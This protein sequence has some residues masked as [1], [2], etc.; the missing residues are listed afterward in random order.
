MPGDFF[1]DEEMGLGQTLLTDADMGILSDAEMGIGVEPPGAFT[2]NPFYRSIASMNAANAL[3]REEIGVTADTVR[4]EELGGIAAPMLAL[5][6]LFTGSLQNSLNPQAMGTDGTGPI[7]NAMDGAMDYLRPGMSAVDQL[8]RGAAPV[9]D[10]AL[11]EADAGAA[12]ENYFDTAARYPRSPDLAEF[13]ADVTDGSFLEGLGQTVMNP[14][15]GSRMVASVGAESSALMAQIIAAYAVG[16]PLAGGVV[17]GAT[18]GNMTLMNGVIE[19][20]TAAGGD[21]TDRDT[22]L[23]FLND[24]EAMAP[25]ME[26][27]L[28]RGVG[29][30]TVD[31]IAG[32][33]GG[34][35][36]TGFHN[37]TRGIPGSPMSGI[38]AAPSRAA[39]AT[40][41]GMA[42]GVGAAELGSQAAL[43]GAGEAVGQVL[44]E[45]QIT[46]P[47]DILL[48]TM[49]EFVTS[50]GSVAANIYQRD[51]AGFRRMVGNIV[52]GRIN[53][54]VNEI[55]FDAPVD[56]AA[57]NDL[58]SYF[59][60]EAIAELN[61]LGVTSTEE[62]DAIAGIAP[63][64]DDVIAAVRAERAS[65]TPGA[66]VNLDNVRR[67]DT[68]ITRNADQR[69][70]QDVGELD[71]SRTGRRA[72][73]DIKRAIAQQ[74]RVRDLNRRAQAGNIDPGFAPGDPRQPRQD[75]P[76]VIN[77]PDLTA[78]LPVDPQGDSP[79][80]GYE[81][82]PGRTDTTDPNYRPEYADRAN[83]RVEGVRRARQAE[84]E[85]ARQEEERLREEPARRAAEQAG[86][87]T[88]AQ[89][90]TTGEVVSD[91]DGYV[92]S[93]R[94]GPVVYAD[95]QQAGRA[96]ARMSATSPSGRTYDHA[97]HPTATR[98]GDQPGSSEALYTIRVR[99]T[100]A[101]NNSQ[102]GTGQDAGQTTNTETRRQSAPTR[103]DNNTGS[104][105]QQ[106]SQSGN[107]QA[108]GGGTNA[109][110][111]QSE[112]H[113]AEARRLGAILDELTSDINTGRTTRMSERGE[114]MTFGSDPN[115]E[116]QGVEHNIRLGRVND[117]YISFLNDRI[118]KQQAR[119]SD[120]PKQPVKETPATLES[121]V[122]DR[123]R[124]EV[125]GAELVR[126]GAADTQPT[127][128]AVNTALDA[129]NK[130]MKFI[131][132]SGLTSREVNPGNT[133][134]LSPRA[135]A[136]RA[137]SSLHAG[138]TTAI[139]ALNAARKGYKQRGTQS[140]GDRLAEANDTLYSRAAEAISM[141]AE[142]EKNSTNAKPIKYRRETYDGKRG[143]TTAH[144]A[145]IGGV[146]YLAR[147]NVLEA[148]VGTPAME[149]GRWEVLVDGEVAEESFLTLTE[150]KEWIRDNAGN[151]SQQGGTEGSSGTAGSPEGR[152]AGRRSEQTGDVR[153]RGTGGRTAPLKGTPTGEGTTG[154]IQGLIDVAEQ[155][156]RD[157]GIDLKRQAY[158][159]LLNETRARRIAAAY[160]A[161]PHAPND[162][163]V[164]A[165]YED[166]I[167]QTRAQY[168]ALVAAGY[169]FTFFDA[170]T[171]PY[172]SSNPWYAMQDIRD[173]KHLAVYAT[174][175]G[176]GTEGIT[177]ADVGDN[178][179]LAD[180]GL[181]WPDQSG[182]QQ[183]V[184]AN[185]LFRAV[186]D[187]FGHGLEGAGFRARGEENA[188]QAHARLFTGPALGALTSETR[189]QNSWLN[190]GPHGETNRSAKT[191][192]TIFAQ[193]KTGLMPEWT[194][195]EGVVPDEGNA[196]PVTADDLARLAWDETFVD[197]FVSRDGW[198]AMSAE[199]STMTKRERARATQ[200]LRE[201]LNT[202]NIDYMEVEGR[203]GPEPESSF[204]I[205][206]DEAR[207]LEIAAGFNQ[208]SIL[209]NNGLV[210]IDGRENTPLKGTVSTGE[211]ARNNPVGYTR[212]QPGGNEFALDL[213]FPEEGSDS[214]PQPDPDPNAPL[215]PDKP[216]F[217]M[218]LA[219]RLNAN[220]VDPEVI[221][222]LAQELFGVSKYAA[223][224]LK[225]HLMNTASA[226]AA[227]AQSPSWRKFLDLQAFVVDY[228][229]RSTYGQALQIA[230]RYKSKAALRVL[231]MFHR[232]PGD[233]TRAAGTN[234]DSA[235]E[236][237]WNETHNRMMDII[238]GVI[239]ED[240][241][242]SNASAA[243]KKT[244]DMWTQLS[245]LVRNPN[246]I[247]PNSKIGK[248]AQ[249]IIQLLRDERQYLV[250]AGVE[251]GDIREGYLPR[252]LDLVKLTTDREN[253]IKD[254]TEVM[255]RHG[256]DDPK[257]AAEKWW[258]HAVGHEK[259]NTHFGSNVGTV[260]P[261]FMKGRELEPWV[262]KI[263]SPIE[264]YY[265]Q[266]LRE[267]L[268]SYF[269]RT[270]QTA[271]WVRRMGR[272]GEKW[273]KEYAPAMRADGVPE[274]Q[275]AIV[276]D[277]IEEMANRRR[278]TL[279][280]TITAGMGWL[281]VANTAGLLDRAT[282]TSLPE[283]A[284]PG[285]RSGYAPD[286][287]VSLYGSIASAINQVP[288]L[289]DRN[290]HYKMIAEFAEDL[291]L[292]M[293]AIEGSYMAM[294]WADLDPQNKIQS[295]VLD[296]YF[297]RIGLEQWTRATRISAVQV[298]AIFIRRKLKQAL[299]G[300]ELAR[301]DLRELGIEPES[302]QELH[303][304]IEKH[305]LYPSREITKASP[306][307]EVYQ[308]GLHTFLDQSIMRPTR[309]DRP[310]WAQGPLGSTIFHLQSFFWTFTR[311]VIFRSGHLAGE[312][313]IEAGNKLTGK[314]SDLTSY[315][316]VKL[317]GPLACLMI[318]YTIGSALSTAR[319]ELLDKRR[320][321]NMNAFE[322][323]LRA[324]SRAGAFGQLDP[325]VNAFTGTRYNRTLLESFIGPAIG[326]P[327]MA[328]TT[329]VRALSRNADETNA[330]ERATAQAF[331]DV[332]LEPA[333]NVAM[334]LTPGGT[335]VT[336]G[337][338]LATQ[339]IGAPASRNFF[340]DL[341]AG[342]E[343]D[344]R[345]SGGDG[346]RSSQRQSS[347]GGNRR[348]SSRRRRS[349]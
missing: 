215:D 37:L 170:E 216:G 119:R 281:R 275:I 110:Q 134:T 88:E 5:G 333:A 307:G 326:R 91:D 148:G 65:V 64:L 317:W 264:K 79:T 291:G 277:S 159:A 246:T 123:S 278:N 344:G 165:A 3:R 182:N 20:I 303:D 267:I 112:A 47:G 249:D 301:R 145:D 11:P 238:K 226:A 128:D 166:L 339:A 349:D 6:E 196:D 324:F 309:G 294:R 30:G 2:L 266:D 82:Y 162:P 75:L 13:M 337:K 176:F 83:E 201:N 334:S 205:L 169:T 340:M 127:A 239:P 73:K 167:R 62:L 43:G 89:R 46:S 254:A 279:H 320:V 85:A 69:Q 23:A 53:R 14:V 181:T 100:A 103:E 150:A 285:V 263:G 207:A 61:S 40:R 180:T 19:G 117:E 50:P 236:R 243:V 261:D 327:A 197:E 136:R 346:R 313:L 244:D 32:G 90:D 280:P 305:G 142:F 336:V 102:A 36:A 1:T 45:G 241:L 312:S 208:D 206:A 204:I 292:I 66:P 78:E 118:R 54:R 341:T 200:R 84:Q 72:A 31:A 235:V 157:N 185:D 247:N 257:A 308:N 4:R 56:G 290:Q 39:S 126:S 130:L 171:N 223:G 104:V 240:I 217:K 7:T 260:N 255:R 191:E 174:A 299:D 8:M 98:K 95:A 188:W 129:Y 224:K 262:D 221:A 258:A 318:Y 345:G 194:W 67:A 214:S 158:Y 74:Q 283:F 133:E 330:A 287:L 265:L 225:Q 173:N 179:L 175:D 151:Q 114:M 146:E 270:G 250:D 92:R 18:E 93:T 163:K 22:V 132:D 230:K 348:S 193:Q 187:A 58:T 28:G 38:A 81:R 212:T 189:G 306:V 35:M 131:N 242:R 27:A 60:P 49:G 232:E 347:R 329:W 52:N 297:R 259:N 59:T 272:N 177:D 237:H 120:A 156:A 144:I 55:D 139:T 269:H 153:G 295:R 99:T 183:P 184:T 115:F 42:A 314:G 298:G 15:M 138:I 338:G 245:R 192:D 86:G 316:I 33:V 271:E 289:R 211:D 328:A 229:N 105:S 125:M 288:G 70:Y 178:P 77:S 24:R 302:F 186:H 137:M 87:N 101:Q 10:T 161:M 160:E 149:T 164:K 140:W 154:P 220:P 293:D 234:Y 253:F 51:P 199:L 233:R 29:I 107:E 12:I 17:S 304:M 122:N 325:W 34:R 331:Y 116:S 124:Y 80:P 222:G 342:E 141:F 256:H 16:G 76:P 322:R 286:M 335:A 268:G 96:A 190:Y 210:Y 251:L 106:P 319:D 71:P 284:M 26:S 311:N 168:D 252:M 195:T 135:E 310:K 296:K 300:S 109:R 111:N 121:L 321:E 63:E 332:I 108:T 44:D 152:D 155:Y 97:V 218:K 21:P 48:E 209:T 41:T 219:N 343:D 273:E 227:F 25:I 172:P 315:E 274:D 213:L 203:Y 113:V 202:E 9:L 68:R 94:G 228:F 147:K 143:W 198:A 276:A 323:R 282:L 248:A 231:D 57:A